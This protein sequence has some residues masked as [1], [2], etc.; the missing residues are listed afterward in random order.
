[1]HSCRSFGPPKLLE[2]M[3]QIHENCIFTVPS[4]TQEAVSRA[5]E[6]NNYV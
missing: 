4:V 2:P 3:R 6:V 5:F 1:M